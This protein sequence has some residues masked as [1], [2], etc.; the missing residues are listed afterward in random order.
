MAFERDRS[1]A[2][3]AL[4]HIEARREADPAMDLAIALIE[5]EARRAVTHIEARSRIGM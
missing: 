5:A 2:V 1:T 3:N 4:R